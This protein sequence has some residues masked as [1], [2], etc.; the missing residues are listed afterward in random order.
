MTR[1]IGSRRSIIKNLAGYSGPGSID[2]NAGPGSMN[3]GSLAVGLSAFSFEAWI[4]IQSIAAAQQ[5]L[6]NGGSDAALHCAFNNTGFSILQR[7]TASPP[8]TTQATFTYTFNLNTWYHVV[9]A[10]SGTGA[11]LAY[12][13]V[14]G[15]LVSTGTSAAN[16]NNVTT[17]MNLGVNAGTGSG[18]VRAYATNIRLVVGSTAY[19]AGSYT[20]P[21]TS[22]TA[23]TNSIFLF[24]V[25]SPSAV[26]TDTVGTYAWSVDTLPYN[27]RT[28]YIF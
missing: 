22:L 4:N 24:N 18:S 11:G 2:F 12:G 3:A 1:F 7:S 15:A 25:L 21:T 19:S 14:N 17:G 10:R 20:V 13:L 27:Y 9:W 26:T 28:P 5:V 8:Y 16:F 6:F 23:I